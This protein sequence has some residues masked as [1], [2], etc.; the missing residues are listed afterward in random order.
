MNF[1]PVIATL[2]ILSGLGLY[3]RVSVGF[4]P[5][6]IHSP[7]GMS[8]TLGGLASVVAL[9]IG[10][11]VM[12]GAS[13]RAAS[14]G[15]ELKQTTEEAKQVALQAVPA[16]PAAELGEDFRVAELGERHERIEI[17]SVQ[18]AHCLSVSRIDYN[19][20]NAAGSRAGAD[21]GAWGR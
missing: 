19:R 2:T 10:F 21:Y 13:L 11:H 7:T 12:R 6:W 20:Q 17:S 18:A 8:L 4:N 14:L 1:M 3:W 16:E 5:G 9:G 15:A